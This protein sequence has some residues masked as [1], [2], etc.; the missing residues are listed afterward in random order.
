MARP[1]A[2]PM[3]GETRRLSR[4]HERRGW[5]ETRNSS[6]VSPAIPLEHIAS[7]TLVSV[8]APGGDENGLVIPSSGNWSET[9]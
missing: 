4:C 3:K 7:L 1:D 6:G 9:C 8:G 2:F 5:P